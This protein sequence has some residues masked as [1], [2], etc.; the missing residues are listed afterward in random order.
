MAPGGD[1]ATNWVRRASV[2][3]LVSAPTEGLA[4]DVGRPEPRLILVDLDGLTRGQAALPTRPATGAVVIGTCSGRLPSYAEA[5]CSSFELTLVP[6]DHEEAGAAW[7]VGVPD[8]TAAASTLID[9]VHEFPT[10]A[11]TL[12]GL[13]RLTAG[14][15]VEAGLVA[16]S[17][18]YSMLM[19]GGEHA[20]WLASRARR[21]VPLATEPVVISRDGDVLTVTLNRPERH[22]AFG[23]QVRDGLAEA[24]DL[25]ADDDCITR[26]LLV[27]AGASFCSGGDLDEFGLTEDVTVAHLIRADR[28]VA[29][30]I[31]SVR[32]RVEVELKGACIGAGIELASF[33]GHVV[34]RPDARIQLPELAMGL[35]PG[36]GGTVGITRRI[37]R[38]R[39][40]WLALSGEPMRL[41]TALRWGLVDE[42]AD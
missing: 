12:T 20:R 18:A 10:T 14:A 41:A 11:Q 39:T 21:E 22:N 5:L 26:V 23:R 29:R 34:A 8:V 37:G 24:F 31:D 9:A 3:E 17:L 40:A 25:V 38:W 4:L 13:L 1:L 15:T 27:G 36:A 7:Q 2:P 28:S 16:E 6:E 33:A 32:D 30:R 42:L 35:V 19:V